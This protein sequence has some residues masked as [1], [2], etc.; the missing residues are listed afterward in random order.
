MRIVDIAVAVRRRH[1]KAHSHSIAQRAGN[2]ALELVKAFIADRN[3]GARGKVKARLARRDVDGARRRVLAVERTLRPAQHF[4]PI[5][6]EEIECR[7]CRSRIIDIVDI[8]A[9]ARFDAVV[10]KTE[11]RPEPADVERGVAR[12]LR[13]ELQRRSQLLHAVDVE[14]AG[15]VDMFTTQHRQGD[16]HGLR[17]FRP[18]PRGDED[19]VAL[20]C[21]RLRG[22]RIVGGRGQRRS[23]GYQRQGGSGNQQGA[24]SHL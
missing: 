14:R 19:N 7:R 18:V 1:G 12:I 24:Q 21:R 15:P 23:R 6:I 10:G 4:D 17:R 13:I 20:I 22:G 11:S 2:R 8:D 3:L 16:R 5:D 9:D